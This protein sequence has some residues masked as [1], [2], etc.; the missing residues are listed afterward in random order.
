MGHTTRRS[1]SSP[2]NSGAAGLVSARVD[3][4]LVPGPLAPFAVMTGAT[5][6]FQHRHRDRTAGASPSSNFSPS[7]SLAYAPRPLISIEVLE[8][9]WA[10]VDA[11]GRFDRV[12]ENFDA[13]ALSG[14]GTERAAA[15]MGQR[16]KPTIASS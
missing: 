13:G 6:R 8:T 11:S 2:F 7:F 4:Q 5:L 3:L 10:P 15:L 1:T 14:A 16:S 9:G 12:V